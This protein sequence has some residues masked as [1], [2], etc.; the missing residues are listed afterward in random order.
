MLHFPEKNRNICIVPD[1]GSL[2]GDAAL[3][4]VGGLAG[5]DMDEILGGRTGGIESGCSG[6]VLTTTSPGGETDLTVL[7]L[8]LDERESLLDVFFNLACSVSTPLGVVLLLLA[9]LRFSRRDSFW[10]KDLETGRDCFIY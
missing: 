8:A 7:T 1:A 6:T 5:G 3:E 4:G 2:A 10:W 9:G